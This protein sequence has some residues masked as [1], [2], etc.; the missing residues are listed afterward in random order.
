[1]LANYPRQLDKQYDRMLFLAQDQ[2]ADAVA[3]AMDILLWTAF[4][5]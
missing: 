4:S 5:S 1:M 3:F 2:E